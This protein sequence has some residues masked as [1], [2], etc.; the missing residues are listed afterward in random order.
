MVRTNVEALRKLLPALQKISDVKKPF[1]VDIDNIVSDD[2]ICGAS[3]G[4]ITDLR[5]SDCSEPNLSVSYLNNA[6]TANPWID[7]QTNLMGLIG[8]G[9]NEGSCSSPM[10]IKSDKN[11]ADFGD[12]DDDSHSD[13]ELHMGDKTIQKMTDT[14]NRSVSK[15]QSIARQVEKAKHKTKDDYSNFKRNEVCQPGNTLLWDLLQ[16]DKIVSFSQ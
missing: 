13:E 8:E 4:E 15:V 7:I 6:N 3:E 14:L 16:D 10:S 5:D 1:G 9:D 2:E 11:M 12:E